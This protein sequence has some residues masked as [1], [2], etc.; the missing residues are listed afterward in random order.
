MILALVAGGLLTG[1][2]LLATSRGGGPEPTATGPAGS[3][4]AVP[5]GPS[6]S[7]GTPGA[8][9]STPGGKVDLGSRARDPKPFTVAELFP[10]KSITIRGNVYKFV[11]GDE[12]TVCPDAATGQ[13]AQ[14]LAQ[15]GCS[16][17]VRGTWQD[18][19]GKH[20]ITVGLANL[21]TTADAS[22]VV[23][24]TREPAKGAFRP[25][26][27]PS[28]AA[29]GFDGSKPTAV[30]WQAQ[31]HYAVFSVV[32]GAT[33]AAASATDPAVKSAGSDLRDLIS[34]ALLRR[35]LSTD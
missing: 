27:V 2:I 30:G 23:A 14:I 12:V 9:G 33:G 24:A 20:L 18:A 29:S 31:G 26:P 15:A 11:G 21:P 6:G 10:D 1:A 16:Q 32:G 28:T 25:Y 7:V 13:V 4:P 35:A 19:G 17:V 8:G 5:P 3:A 34:S 22:K